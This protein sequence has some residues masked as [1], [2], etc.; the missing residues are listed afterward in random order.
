MTETETGPNKDPVT[1]R[2]LTGNIGGGRPRGSRNKLG[3]AFLTDIYADWR[4]HGAASI[5]RVRQERP[6]VYLRVVASILP[7]HLEL[8]N[9]DNIFDGISDD[10][11]DAILAYTCNALGIADEDAAGASET[12]H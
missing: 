11:L 7:K 1:G 9:D 6:D 2:F 4:E 3:E 10:Q 12:P 8:K 5:E